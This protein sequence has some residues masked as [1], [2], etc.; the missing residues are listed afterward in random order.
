MS[1]YTADAIGRHGILDQGICFLAKP[2]SAREI[3]L[4]VREALSQPE[5][6]LETQTSR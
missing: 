3:A 4:K 1:G 5:I 2:F 6:S